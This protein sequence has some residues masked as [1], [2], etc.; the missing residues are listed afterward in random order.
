MRS[1]K[2]K[3]LEVDVQVFRDY[4]G[5]E[6]S[7]LIDLLKSLPEGTNWVGAGHDTAKNTQIMF[8]ENESWPESPMCNVVPRFIPSFRKHRDGSVTLED[9]GLEEFKKNININ[10]DEDEEFYG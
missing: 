6:V 10:D 3:S 1:R 5:F 7:T 9:N 2:I 4:K 8:F